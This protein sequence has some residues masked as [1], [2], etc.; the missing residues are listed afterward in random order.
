MV[1]ITE[2]DDIIRCANCGEIISK[3]GEY[4]QKYCFNCG[5]P[6]LIDAIMEYEEKMEKIKGDTVKEVADKLSKNSEI[7]QIV[8]NMLEEE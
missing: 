3:T 4:T 5:N 7:K 2:R 6:L 1:G 8:L